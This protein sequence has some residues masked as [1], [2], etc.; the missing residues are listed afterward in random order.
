[1]TLIVQLHLHQF[2]ANILLYSGPDQILPLLSVLGAV[3][4]FLLIWWQRFMRFVRRVWQAAFKS[5]PTS[6]KK[7]IDKNVETEKCQTEK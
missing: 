5:S 2:A 6:E 1:V 7:F 3:I 4:G